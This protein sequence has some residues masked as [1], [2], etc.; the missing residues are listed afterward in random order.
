MAKSKKK[1]K[2]RKSTKSA[3]K[4]KRPARQKMI[5]QKSQRKFLGKDS[6]ASLQQAIISLQ[7]T[8]RQF[9]DSK[10][11]DKHHRV[12]ARIEKFTGKTKR[13]LKLEASKLL[14]GTT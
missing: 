14:Q 3:R 12:L 6:H 4:T 8:D 5:E 7:Q 1:P 9:R 13:S 11:S 10:W 2:K